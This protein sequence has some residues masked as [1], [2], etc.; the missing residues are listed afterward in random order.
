MVIEIEVDFVEEVGFNLFEV[1]V[2][3]GF[4]FLIVVEFGGGVLL[5]V[6]GKGLKLCYFCIFLF[7]I[8][9]CCLRYGCLVMEVGCFLSCVF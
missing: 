8:S 9:L 7:I 2:V 1:K 4:F 3:I 5:G 6:E